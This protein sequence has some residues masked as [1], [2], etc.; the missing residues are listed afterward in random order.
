MK[1]ATPK[2]L[3]ESCGTGPFKRTYLMTRK[4]LF[5]LGFL[6]SF[7]IAAFA[8]PRPVAIVGG[9][10]IT[11]T[12]ESPLEEMTILIRDGRI[13]Y[14]GDNPG[15]DRLSEYDVIDASGKWV[16]PG[17]IDTNVHLIL[18]TIPEFYIKYEDRLEEIAIQSAQVGLKFGMTTMA[19]SWGPLEPLLA[20]RD[21]IRAG[22]FV[23]SDV[24]IA[25]NIIGT[26]G[27]FTAY[28]MGGWGLR[29]KSLRYGDWVTPTVQRRINAL[30]E[31]GMGPDLMAVTP[32]EAALR[33]RDYIARGV[34][35]I[36]LGIS[37]HGIEPVEPLMFSD[38][39]L[40]AMVGEIRRAGI[41]FQTHT[42]TIASLEQAL[43]LKPDFLQHPN[44]MSP[45]WL[46]ASNEQKDAIRELI[47]EI[48]EIGIYS[49]LMAVPEKRQ[50]E[51]YQ[52][53][54]SSQSDDPDINEIMFFRQ[55]WFEGITYDQMAAGVKVWLDAGIPY[56]IATDQGPE[57]AD[58]GPTIWGRLGRAH[59]DRMIGLQDAGASPM[60][61]L[62]A[63][64]RNGA[65]AYGLGES[66]GT[67]EEGKI[68]DLLILAADP[69]I[70]IGNVRQIFMIL[71]DGIIVDRD[72]LPI[73]KVLDYDP[74]LA[75]PY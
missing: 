30:W 24:L 35:F 25:G 61:I 15:Q 23:G 18:N 49:G 1:V 56:T 55:Q 52:N 47:A 39:V 32:D 33:M 69:M 66:K 12:G 3:S 60:D 48:D 21:R 26:G 10:V 57:T 68:A 65:M 40:E 74:A 36:K 38:A 20:A 73:V 63:A 7:S 34:D 58:L 54:N 62:V 13:E 64:T 75:W 29:G 22:E 50:L 6:L 14:I 71:K 4:I 53:W 59:F 72:A 67:I 42:F 16:T 11:A 37:G 28:F 44:V 31:A 9:T 8:Q 51:I 27:P 5:L 2:K 70:D 43:R 46:S 41:P 17:L 45:S 19:D